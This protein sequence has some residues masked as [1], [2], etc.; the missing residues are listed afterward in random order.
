MTYTVNM[1]GQPTDAVDTTNSP[2]IT[3]A[4]GAL[5]TAF[6]A[7]RSLTNDTSTSAIL[8]TLYFNKRLQPC[9]IAADSYGTTAPSSCSDSTNKGNLLDAQYNFGL[10]T[11]D[12]G[13][14]AKVT[15]NRTGMSDRST[16]YTY[17]AL[18]R[19]SAAY[20][21]GL[22]G[23]Y[24]CGETFTVDPW[25]NLTTIAQESS[26]GGTGC[27]Q[28]TLSLSATVQNR[29]TTG[30]S[31]DYGYDSAGNLTTVPSP[32]SATYTYNAEG[33]MTQ[34]ATSS[35]VG[36]VYDGDGQRVEKTSSGSATKL[37]WYGLGGN[38]LDETDG[39]GTLASEYAFFGG[40]RIGRRDASGNVFFYFADHLGTARAIVQQGHTSPCY[41]ADFYPFGGERDYTSTC[42]P[43]NRFT[44]YER[45]G[46]SGNDD[47]SARYYTS[48]MGR[49]LSPDPVNA[50]AN[51]TSPQTWNAYAYVGNNPLRFTDP[52]GLSACDYGFNGGGNN[53]DALCAELNDDSWWQ[54]LRSPGE[55]LANVNSGKNFNGARCPRPSNSNSTA[56]FMANL[57][58]ATLVA[59]TNTRTGAHG[60]PR[61]RRARH[62]KRFW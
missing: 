21:D 14:V 57:M 44:G 12:N 3:Y 35:T 11:A 32:G 53:D 48:S 60:T 46:E 18:N 56:C 36:Y 25:A 16:S 15:N 26:H 4:A 5:Y 33:Q 37:Y 34:A 6:G 39:S 29:L 50:G 58:P 8:S 23:S 31:P 17:D 2:N 9:R 41:D 22:S 27:G 13:N 59:G 20:T 55:Q 19:I 42:V 61:N 52:L 1:V 24:C 51:A 28:E 30:T 38:V 49:F 43:N 10:S 40:S 62:I 45:D 47:A 54:P 7:L